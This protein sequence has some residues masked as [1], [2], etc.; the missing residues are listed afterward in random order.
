[1]ERPEATPGAVRAAQPP[2]RRCSRRAHGVAALAVAALAL[3]SAAAV[4]AGAAPG[5]AVV[6]AT[7]GGDELESARLALRT[8]QQ[9]AA[10]RA[11]RAPAERGVAEAQ[12]LLGLATLAG[13]TADAERATALR[14]LRAAGS[15]GH[16][17]AAFALAGL[18]AGSQPATRRR[19]RRSATAVCRWPTKRPR[20]APSASCASR[21]CS[22]LPRPTMRPRSSAAA[23]R[24]W[25]ARRTSSGA[26]RW[27]RP[28]P[29]APATRSPG[30]C[31]LAPT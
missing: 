30:C 6:P 3:L 22:A 27:R 28:R 31:A 14:W 1:M 23:Q 7:A 15:Q 2:I 8:R 29:Q 9:A 16:A 4:A 24:S 11:L 25:C 13:G 5:T 17:A 21:S 19:S 20:G 12:Y 10:L 26:R 18:G